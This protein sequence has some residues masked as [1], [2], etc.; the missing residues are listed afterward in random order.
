MTFDKAINGLSNDLA[1]ALG[2]DCSMH[3]QREILRRY[4]QRAMVIGFDHFK[5]YHTDVV[6]MD[7]NGYEVNRYQGVNEAAKKLKIPHQSISNVI[8][9]KKHS[10]HGFMFRKAT[11]IFS[12]ETKKT[13]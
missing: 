7:L 8:A 4:I 13:A 3:A 11:D 10:T 9:G 5:R 12:I 6:Q 2:I 1:D